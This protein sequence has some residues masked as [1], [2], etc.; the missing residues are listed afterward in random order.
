[1]VR[2]R[3]ADDG[4]VENDTSRRPE[5][6]GLE[7]S[8]TL[9]E[10]TIRT[11]GP[12]THPKLPVV[13]RHIVECDPHLVGA[14]PLD[15]ITCHRGVPGR[16]LPVVSGPQTR[17]GPSHGPQ[18]PEVVG[19]RRVQLGQHTLDGTVPGR[20][21]AGLARPRQIGVGA[22]NSEHG[23]AN[24]GGV[25]GRQ[26]PKSHEAVP[27][28]SPSSPAASQDR[29]AVRHVPGVGLGESACSGKVEGH[30]GRRRRRVQRVHRG[31]IGRPRPEGA[32]REVRLV[33]LDAPNRTGG[34]AVEMHQP[35]TPGCEPDRSD[36]PGVRGDIARGT[37][38]HRRVVH[39]P[40]TG[41]QRKQLG[42][43][44]SSLWK[45]AAGDDGSSLRTPSVHRW[46]PGTNDSAPF[47]HATS[48]RGSRE[49]PLARAARRCRSSPGGT[50]R[51][52]R[53]A[54]PWR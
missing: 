52:H 54:H 31:T 42:S 40:V 8:V 53:G 21:L 43:S 17:E 15:R 4:R 35:G 3:R 51:A 18:T 22:E 13:A 12:T 34:V 30:I 44:A 11:V 47:D 27:I 32:L 16:R 7:S 28:E 26:T 24:D 9:I 38:D 20:T 19:Q 1:M 10:H 45:G 6:N 23:L 5:R 2:I 50:R 14:L 29:S 46:L 37:V 39:D 25:G 33:H 48:T 41:I 36:R 49:A